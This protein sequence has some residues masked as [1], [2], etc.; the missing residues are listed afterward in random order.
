[1]SLP[2]GARLGPYEILAP[3][4]AGGMGEVYRARDTRLERTV[5]IKVLPQH[6]SASAEVRQ[7]FEREARTISSLSHPHIC[8]LYDVGNQDGTEYLVME[9]LEGETLAE[10]LLKGALPGEQVLRYGIETADALDKAHRQVIVHRDLKPGNIMLTKSGV[11]LLDF[12]LAKAVQPPSPSSSGSVLPTRAA[13]LTQEGT[14]LGTFQYMAPEQLEGKEADAR[15]DIFAFGTVLYEMATGRKAFSGS[16]QAS[17]ISS[18]MSSEPPPISTLQPM[19]PPALDRVVKT[20]LAKD[21]DE[22]WQT[23]HDVG[24]QLKWIAEGGSQAG[25]P[26]PVVAR[27]RSRERLAWIVAAAAALA[28]VWLAVSPPRRTAPEHAV[29]LS[30]SAPAKASFEF[31]GNL[32]VSPDGSRVAFL[33]H[34]PG[35]KRQLWVRPLDSLSAQALAGTEGAEDMFWSPDGHFLG[36]FADGK[37]KKI[38]ATGGPPQALC[39]A[40][41]PSGGAWGPQGIV[42]APN[43]LGVLYRVPAEGGKPSAVTKL[44]AREEAHRYPSFLPDGRHFVFLA[45]SWRTEDHF[46]RAGSLDSVE[47]VRLFQAVTNPVF[48]PPEHLLF[49]RGGSL[50]AQG[51]DAKSLKPLGEP[52]SVGEQIAETGQN[53]HFDFS[54]SATGVLLYRSE[55]PETQLTWFDRAGKRLASLGEPARHGSIEIS[56]DGDRIVFMRLDPDGRPGNLWMLD[57]SRGTTSRL[58][59]GAASDICPV[60]SPDGRRISYSSMRSGLGDLYERPASPAGADQLVFKS[61]D[62][63][64]PMSWSSDGRF[65]LF[66]DVAP[67]T[68]SDLWVLPVAGDR[69]PVP[70]AQT[71]FFEGIAQFSP[72]GAWVAYNSNESGRMEVYV[73]SFSDPAVRIQVSSGG[74]LRPRWRGDGKEL[75]Y[76]S[77]GKILSVDIQTA[78]APQAGN[79]KELFRPPPAPGIGDYAVSRDGQRFLLTAPVEENSSAPVTVVLHWTAEVKK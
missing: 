77:G 11:K 72:D 1:M 14:I 15:T 57:L 9:F 48:I 31:F 34:S 39:D 58:T 71:S 78:A 22:R 29:R 32:V 37:L 47:S 20:C 43:D 23:A 10:R 28:A 70:F 65:L 53:H 6:L 27:R 25:I 24:L 79:P 2:A 54:A 40:P 12:G 4:G 21:P 41:S 76:F 63:K 35:G 13:D 51:F 66:E 36:F 52:A 16:S 50:L 74:G 7:R 8:A 56:P 49:V 61:A 67:T 46:I 73:R 26:A 17:L 60:W 30:L 55:N 69:K 45:D 3:V 33:A 75:F 19:T 44:D 5:A 64:C 18:I 42:F 59:S 68:K 62:N 38:Q